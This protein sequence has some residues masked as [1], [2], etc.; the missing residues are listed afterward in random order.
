MA[1]Q[2][3]KLLEYALLASSRLATSTVHTITRP[4][5]TARGNLS[6]L[7]MLF[8]SLL[9]RFRKELSSVG[10]TVGV[11]NNNITSTNMYGE[12]I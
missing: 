12:T 1:Q 7:R 11:D 6:I 3:S 4:N 10:T 2:Q 9:C 8:L 5:N